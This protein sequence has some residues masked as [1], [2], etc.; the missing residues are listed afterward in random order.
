VSAAEWAGPYCSAQSAAG[1]E[2]AW[3]PLAGGPLPRGAVRFIVRWRVTGFAHPRK[4]T[5]PDA[6]EA[7]D[8]ARRIAAARLLRAG[9]DDR[10]WPLSQLPAGDPVG[11]VGAL[12]EGLAPRRVGTV[13]SVTPGG[14]EP[15]G[16]D[17]GHAADGTCGVVQFADV[18][19]RPQDGSGDLGI[20][21]ELVGPP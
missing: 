16:G 1:E 2:L 13:P 9:R 14:G 6:A 8:W 3:E 21:G 7:A 20:G 12:G 11:M 18:G 10:G 5:F 17:G 19:E 4:R 15:P